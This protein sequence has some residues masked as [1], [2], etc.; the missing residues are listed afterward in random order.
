VS[1]YDVI[2]AVVFLVLLAFGAAAIEAWAERRATRRQ[3]DN[4]DYL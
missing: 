3:V 4:S 1:V 2:D